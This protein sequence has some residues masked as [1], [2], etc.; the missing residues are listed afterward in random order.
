MT[1]AINLR[2]LAAL[3]ICA[4]TEETRYHLKGV[5]LEITPRH[6]TY[7]AADGHRMVAHREELAD[8]AESNTVLGDFIIPLANCKPFKLGKHEDGAAT[9]AGDASRLSI[10]FNGN[11]VSFAPVDGSFPDWRR[12]IPSAIDGV[13]AHFNPKYLADFAKVGDMLGYHGI[14]TIAHNGLA[15][16]CVGWRDN[17]STLVVLMPIRG[18]SSADYSKPAWLDAP[19]TETAIAA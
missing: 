14:P 17:T 16:A 1:S 15:P 9:I 11:A 6:T 7:V 3:S 12:V 5:K 19:Q 2:V 8:E 13:T 18:P 10:D 4:S